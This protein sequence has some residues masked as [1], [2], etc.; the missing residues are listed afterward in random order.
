MPYADAFDA[1]RM[2]R[3][4]EAA[5]NLA[6]RIRDFTVFRNLYAETATITWCEPGRDDSC[7]EV[8]FTSALVPKS[9]VLLFREVVGSGA[10]ISAE[11]FGS[12]WPEGSIRGR[13]T[14]TLDGDG[15]VADLRLEEFPS[16]ANG[17]LQRRAVLA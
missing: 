17:P 2:V 4:H 6:A 14:F 1:E 13:A 8:G 16:F 15:R 7:H 10:S 12:G 5:F 9:A 11:Y 3:L